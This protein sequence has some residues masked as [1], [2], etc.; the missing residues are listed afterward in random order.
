MDLRVMAPALNR[1]LSSSFRARILEILARLWELARALKA[2]CFDRP[3]CRIPNFLLMA[4][5]R[6]SAS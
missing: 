4:V 6:S 1:Y 2:Y 3:S 5:S